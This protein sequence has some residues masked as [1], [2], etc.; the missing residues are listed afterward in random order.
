VPESML[1]EVETAIGKLKRCKSPGYAHIPPEL[2]RT[3]GEILCSEMYK[4]ISPL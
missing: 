4:L 1:V 2:S 3:G